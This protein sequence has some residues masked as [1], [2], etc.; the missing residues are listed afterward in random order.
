MNYI[1]DVF[2]NLYKYPI[3]FYEWDFNKVINLVKVPLFKLNSINDFKYNQV[4]VDSNFIKSIKNKSP[5]KNACVFTNDKEAL[6]IQ[7]DDSGFIRN[8]SKFLFEEEEEI[9]D[10]SGLLIEEDINYQII[11]KDLYD[12]K[13]T[14]RCNERKNVFLNELNNSSASKIKYIYYEYFNKKSDNISKI[15]EELMENYNKIYDLI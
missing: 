6:F 15:K 12:Y 5:L 2:I 1:Y 9:L 11:N 8:K 3:D 13:L 10:Y 7:F 14:K 4:K